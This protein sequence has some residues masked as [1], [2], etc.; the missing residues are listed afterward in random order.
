MEVEQSRR[1]EVE[2]HGIWQEA[3]GERTPP[4]KKGREA[5]VGGG[6]THQHGKEEGVR[7]LSSIV[8]G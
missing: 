1:D 3:K 2:A 6:R 7:G 5:Q 8:A 4:K